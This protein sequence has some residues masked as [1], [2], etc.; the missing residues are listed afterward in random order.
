MAGVIENIKFKDLRDA[1]VALNDSGFLKGKGPISGILEKDL[2]EE[3]KLR[4]V[5]VNKEVIL[6]NFMKAI[7]AIPDVDGKFPGPKVALDFFNSI[8]DMESKAAQ[9]EQKAAEKTE[10]PKKEKTPKEP[11]EKKEK[12]PKEPKP[13]KEKK[14]KTP[15]E[16]KE[17]GPTKKD[18][19]IEY[20][21]REGGA[22][23]E[24]MAKRCTEL[25]LGDFDRNYGTVKLWIP[26]IGFDVKKVT[27]EEDGKKIIR[28][29]ADK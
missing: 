25:G 19:V 23:L 12:T 27:T 4:L 18:V 16:P 17:K 9:A 14:E 7:E 13:P 21:Q 10:K 24:E 8:V 29:V 5:G 3:G 2:S 1:T 28:Y 26:K 15:K 22:T 6:S 11:K 20:L